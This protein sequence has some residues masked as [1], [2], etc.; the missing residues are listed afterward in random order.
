MLRPLLILLFL[1]FSFNANGSNFPRP[2]KLEPAVQFWTKVYTAV[3]TNQGY[4]HDAVNLSVVYETLDLP[5]YASRGERDQIVAREQARIKTALAQLGK[6][7]RSGLNETEQRVLAAWP[8]GTGNQTFLQA[9]DQLRFQLGQSDRFKAGLI[10]SGQWRPHIRRV[11]AM[12]NLPEELEILPHVESSFNPSA[13]SKVAAAGMWQFMPAT[14]RQY[15]R[16]D[17]LMDER[18][19]PFIATEGAAKLLKYN[20]RV[21]GTW[22]LALTAYNHGAGGIMRAAKAMGTKDIGLIAEKY[23]G[24]AFGFASRNFYASFLA[25]LDVDR[26]AERYFGAVKLDAPTDYDRVSVREYIPVAALADSAGVSLAELRA[27][28]PALLDT[29]WSGEKYI[30]R[31]YE[32]RIPRGRLSN[33]LQDVIA[34][35]PASLRFGYQKPDVLHTIRPG[36][37]LSVI[38]ARYNTSVAKLMALNGLQNS[39]RIRAGQSLKLPGAVQQDVGNTVAVAAVASPS[40][41]P[42]TASRRPAEGKLYVIKP[43]DSL[44]GI[45]RRFN[46]SQH[47]LAAWNQIDGKSPIK[48]GQTLRIGGLSSGDSADKYVIQAGDSLWAIA[49]RF[50]VSQQDLLAWNG[51]KRG[52][53]IKPGDTL[54]LASN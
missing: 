54:R 51:L 53:I 31:G 26:N 36:E 20:H 13:Y 9:A 41:Q 30:P 1:A 39:H 50:N 46:V 25:A 14:A 45:A 32:V 2:A 7:K 15:M 10:R 6:G 47:E 37:S 11:L 16:V 5:E 48:P 4:L 28:N 8:K 40:A 21:T 24:P 22:P 17:E 44:W 52:Q 49:R 27:H 23:K 3:S 38:A 19:D 33:P 18:M 12:H 43:G 29:I 42:A 34:A 35:I